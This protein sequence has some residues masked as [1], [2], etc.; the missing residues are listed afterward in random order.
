MKKIRVLHLIKTLDLGGAE[1]NL[2][3]LVEATDRERFDIHVGYSYGGQIEARFK[4][5]G[6]RLFKYASASHR[7]KSLATLA[8][9]AR[10]VAYIRRHG[11]QIVHTHNFNSHIWGSMA[12]K[13][14]RVKIVEHVHDF[15]Y[16]EPEDFARRR[17]ES[18]QYRWIKYLKN[19]SDRVI[20]LT[21][22]NREFLTRRGFYEPAR[23]R[24]IQ[25]GIP[26]R[27]PA[28]DHATPDDFAR[29]GILSGAPVIFTAARIAPEKNLDLL[30]SVAPA[31]RKEVP[32][33]VFLVAG[34]GPL[35]EAYRKET[36]WRGLD[37][38]IKWIGFHADALALASRSAIFLLP[39]FLELHSIAV[40]EAMSVG[41]PVVISKG[42]GCHD[43]FI[44]SGEN[45]VLVDPFGAFGWAEAIIELLKNEPL[46]RA[47]GER[48]R[49]T[50][51]SR[52]T[53]ETAARKKEELY[54]ELA[55]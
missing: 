7:V 35:L 5:A 32:G 47:I 37:D 17:G 10:L 45:G 1:T 15:R 29:W 26:V 30:F 25:N 49:S 48:G 54:A 50:C 18:A 36:A 9:V 31:V 12:A 22:Q 53:I 39:S 40:L 6:V 52:F 42:V 43:E 33:A 38:C 51:L 27:P 16:L 8:I 2:F 44:R 20:V 28:A 23:V 24:M 11:I 4:K 46:R 34:E 14:A 13:I 21:D 55:R 41:V 3:N 19:V